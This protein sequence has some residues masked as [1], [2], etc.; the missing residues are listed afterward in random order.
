MF[1]NNY[2]FKNISLKQGKIT[3][4]NLFTLYIILTRQFKNCRKVQGIIA[5]PRECSGNPVLCHT[6]ENRYL[7][8]S[9]RC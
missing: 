6:C 1:D 5:R 4:I 7:R 9:R 8:D 3:L 2:R